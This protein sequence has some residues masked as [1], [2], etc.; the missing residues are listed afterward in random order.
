MISFQPG[1]EGK[2]NRD[3]TPDLLRLEFVL[4]EHGGTIGHSM[5]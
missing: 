2:F 4:L 3:G 1:M 5:N